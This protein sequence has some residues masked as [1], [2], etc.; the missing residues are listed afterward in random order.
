[1]GQVYCYEGRRLIG[2]QIFRD[3]IRP[4]DH[5]M[6]EHSSSAFS[7]G[8]DVSLRYAI[9][10]VGVN[11]T[12]TKML[13]LLGTMCSKFFGA[14]DTVVGMITFDISVVMGSMKFKGLF[15]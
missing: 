12:V 3:N 9:L 13:L 15:G 7:D 5:C 11:T 14:K 2:E 4:F 8:T 1:M 10:V 6:N